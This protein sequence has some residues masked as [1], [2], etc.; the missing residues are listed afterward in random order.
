MGSQRVRCK[1]I[2]KEW[3]KNIDGDYA[4]WLQPLTHHHWWF[5]TIPLPISVV[6]LKGEDNLAK[7][8]Y[9]QHS[10]HRLNAV[11]HGRNVF[12]QN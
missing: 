12:S 6:R 1:E 2:D 3:K 11:H 5:L 10:A 9:Y 4:C 8:V 7:G